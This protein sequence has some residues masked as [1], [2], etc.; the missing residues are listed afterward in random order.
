MKKILSMITACSLMLGTFITINALDSDDTN[1][2]NT[3]VLSAALN[4]STDEFAHQ[5]S[6]LVNKERAANGLKPVKMSPQLSKAATVRAVEIKQ[7]FSHTRPDGTSCFTAVTDMGITYQYVAENIAYGQKD[8]EAVMNAWM[9]SSGHRANILSDKMDYIGVGVN[10]ENG[11]YYWT[12]F[13]ATSSDLSND[14]YLP[15]ENKPVVTTGASVTTYQTSLTQTTEPEVTQVTTENVTKP[16]TT[17]VAQLTTVSGTKPESSVT[18]TAQNTTTVSSESVTTAPCPVKP[19]GSVTTC[20]S[21]SSE[22][23]TQK[24]C[25]TKPNGCTGNQFENIFPGCNS[26]INQMIGN[27]IQSGNCNIIQ[28][29]NCNIIQSGNCNSNN[30]CNK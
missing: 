27:I 21:V 23:N 3:G 9:N 28:S 4:A 26:D 25:T 24:P 13:F 8:P 20:T 15:E 16:E 5:V 12:Q 17:T 30:S 7:N 19:E 14:S 29:G 10:Y 2:N 6:A 18:T 22:C 1:E 11:T